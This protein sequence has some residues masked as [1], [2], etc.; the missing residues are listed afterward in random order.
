[1]VRQSF[2]VYRLRQ[3]KPAERNERCTDYLS[4]DEIVENVVLR[5]T[6]RPVITGISAKAMPEAMR[7]YSIAVA[8]LLSL[9]NLI[10]RHIG[11]SL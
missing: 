3:K 11:N 5:W 8:A 4:A 10:T 6:P 7:P 1:V 2:P 9:Q